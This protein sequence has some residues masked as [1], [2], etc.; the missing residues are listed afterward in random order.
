MI[1]I[2]GDFLSHLVE[3]G[4]FSAKVVL[5]AKGAIFF[6]VSEEHRNQ[7]T[8]GISYEDNYK[9]NALAAMLAPGK[10]EIRYHKGFTDQAVAGIIGA[11]LAHPDLAFMKGWR[12]TY[13]GRP[14]SAP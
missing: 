14:L 7:K 12:V 9:G 6:P 2:G 8:E 13:Q 11:V 4:T 3:Q 1:L 10:I 5:N